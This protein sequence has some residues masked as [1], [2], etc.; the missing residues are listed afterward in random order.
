MPTP[1]AHTV[2]YGGN[3]VSV[4]VE[5]EGKVL[6]LDAGTGIRALGTALM[7]TD[8]EIFLLLSHLHTDHILG[9]PYFHPL[10]EPGR[11]VHLLDYQKDGKAW[12]LLDLFNGV[13]FPL[14]PEDLLCS[15]H[16]V[17]S[18]GLAYLRA[19]GFAVEALPV[20]H[21]GG[22]FGY[23]LTHQGR[24]FVFIPDNELGA[25]E[26]TTTFDEF[27]AFC[28]DAD[29]LCHD[30]QYLAD[31]MP[32][33][34]GWGHSC[35]HH[36]IELAIAASVKHLI[37]FH[38]DPDRT[39]DALDALQADARARLATH[40]IACTTAYEGMTLDFRSSEI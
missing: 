9:F 4:S 32:A 38:H 14:S 25:L 13:H 26:K 2:R 11:Q 35:V 40:D 15:Y 5:I 36:V 23:R 28:R 8:E 10:Y 7:G 22:A 3:T 12:S 17:Q 20:N 29:V 24:R 6:I 21:P 1:G 37:L 33:K 19:H 16:R 30:A 31:D 34:H 27:A 18:N 39:D